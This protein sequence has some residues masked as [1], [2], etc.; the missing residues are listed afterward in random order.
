VAICDTW[1]QRE[2]IACDIHSLIIIII[3]I[4]IIITLTLLQNVRNSKVPIK[5]TGKINA[6]ELLQDVLK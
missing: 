4:I 3:I 2:T 5:I 6:P 1:K